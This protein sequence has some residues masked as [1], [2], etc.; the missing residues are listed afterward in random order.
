[1]NTLQ[2]TRIRKIAMETVKILNNLAPSYIL[3]LVKFK[4]TNYSFRYQNLA[5]LPR[6]NSESY[7]RKSFR[8][9]TAHIWNSLQN[10]LRTTTDFKEFGMLIRPERVSHV[11]VLCAS[12]ICNFCFTCPVQFLSSAMTFN[13]SVYL[14]V[15]L[16]TF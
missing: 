14:F 10:E 11:N 15:C 5:E 12:L 16:V 6:V 1:M 9:E 4:N 3:D 13:C 7:G 2:I 8:Y